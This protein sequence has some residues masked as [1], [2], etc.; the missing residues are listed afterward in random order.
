MAQYTLK[1]DGSGGYIGKTPIYEQALGA[2]RGYAKTTGLSVLV[3]ETWRGR[4]REI[5]VHPDG[6]IT[7]LWDGER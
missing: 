5:V 2:A 3:A 4:T 1:Y 7:H 6:D